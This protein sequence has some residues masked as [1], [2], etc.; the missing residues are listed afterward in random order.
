MPE[1]CDRVVLVKGTVLAQGPTVDTFTQENLEA[2]FGG[3]LRHFV[4]SGSQLHD[5]DDQRS[6]TILT[7]DERPMVLYDQKTQVKAAEGSSE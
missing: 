6:V 1:F 7:D 5:D 2:A 3:V 4:L